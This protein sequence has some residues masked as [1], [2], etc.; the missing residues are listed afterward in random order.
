VWFSKRQP[1][2]ESSVFG[3]EFV[4][5]KNGSETCYGLPYKMRMTGV[6]L[7]VPEFVYG[8]N[9]YVFHNTQRP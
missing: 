4:A 6:T 9:M 1:N 8:E 2:M 5:M 7:G 3:A